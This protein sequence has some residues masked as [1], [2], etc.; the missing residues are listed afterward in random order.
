MPILVLF[1]WLMM[2]WLA[3]VDHNFESSDDVTL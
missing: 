2:V 1:F 3:A